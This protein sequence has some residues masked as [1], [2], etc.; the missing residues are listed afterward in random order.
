[1]SALK[2]S[3]L[4]LIKPFA[5]RDYALLA[6]ALVFS[7]FAAGMWSVAMVY[8]VRRLDGGPVE[9]SMVATANAATQRCLTPFRIRQLT[10]RV[11]AGERVDR[12]ALIRQLNALGYQRADA[13]AEAGEYAVRGSL[14]DLLPAG[15][16]GGLRLDFFGDEVESIRRFPKPHEFERMI[17]EAGF[18]RT[19]TETLMGGLVCIWSGWK[20]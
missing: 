20:V 9:L 12:D 10:R 8:Q 7:T 13:V 11:A 2:T 15:E 17:G 19:H 1:M 6:S 5:I 16:Q 18:V 3:A 14:I 4:R